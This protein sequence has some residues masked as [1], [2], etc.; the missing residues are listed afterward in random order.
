MMKKLRD[1]L[2]GLG[3]LL[4]IALVSTFLATFLP[5]YIGAVF[6]AVVLG[7][8]IANVFKP[9]RAVFGQGIKLGL[10]QFLKLAIV[11][12]GAGISVQEIG[13][14]GGKGLLIIVSLIAFVFAATFV[15]GKALKVSLRQVLLIA[16]GVSICGNTAVATTAPL[17]E[18]EDDEVAMAVGIV[19]LFGV[20]SV[21]SYPMIGLAL[22]MSD[23]VFGVWAGTAI[24]DTSQVVAAGFIFSDEAGKVA[25]TIK[26]TRN[27]MI[28]PVVLLVAYFYRRS[29]REKGPAKARALDMFPTF[30]LGFLAF[31]GLNSL[32]LLSAQAS[33]TLVT[34]AKFL[35][36]LALSG[37][38]LGV[39]FKKFARM[40]WRPFVLGFAVELLLALAALGLITMSFAPAV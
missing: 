2:P 13:S 15:I 30:I 20:L 12:L 22:G 14:L 7:L 9:D 27:V 29:H 5:P 10:G 35:I 24:N 36:L 32:G 21:L 19:T 16:A 31:A 40:G 23:T 26:L 33:E 4:G 6:V 18:A 11:L 1:Y 8:I 3:L 38:G 25:T 39:D 17:I 28:I 37:I 34:T